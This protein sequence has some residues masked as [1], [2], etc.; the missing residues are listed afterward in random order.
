ME[1]LAAC[2]VADVRHPT[3]MQLKRLLDIGVPHSR[4]VRALRLAREAPFSV[5]LVEQ[6]HGGGA[7]IL[8]QHKRMNAETLVSCSA[9]H[10][11]RHFFEPSEIDKQ[12][13]KIRVKLEKLQSARASF[14]GLNLFVQRMSR[15][16]FLP[17]LHNDIDNAVGR[18]Q[19]SLAAGHQLYTQLP[20]SAKVAFSDAARSVRANR[21]ILIAE[22]VAEC[23][24]ELLVLEG[25]RRDVE[26]KSKPNHM[27]S[28]RLD[29]SDIDRMCEMSCSKDFQGL[30]VDRMNIDAVRPPAVPTR[31][32]QS[33]IVAEETACAIPEKPRPWWLQMV[34]L[35]R[36]RFK[37]AAFSW[38]S[39]RAE[40][41]YFI[42]YST[43]SPY[44]VTFLRLQR[45]ERVLP[46][47][48][49]LGPAERLSLDELLST[50]FTYCTYTFVLD[51]ELLEFDEEDMF[52][53][54]DLRFEDDI[55]TTRSSP[56]EFDVFTARFPRAAARARVP[57]QGGQRRT[58]FKMDARAELLNEFPWLTEE[59][60]NR[61]SGGRR[62]CGRRGDLPNDENEGSGS[63][64]DGPGP[65]FEGVDLLA[66]HDEVI[67]VAEEVRAI[68]EEFHFDAV[69]MAF[70]TRVLAGRWT[71][72]HRHV[73]A[74]AIA[75]Y[76]RGELAKQ[77]CRTYKLPAQKSYAFSV[78][79]HAAANKLATEYCRRADLFYQI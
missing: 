45:R 4:V 46:A 8:R 67:D 56:V 13:A 69:E 21:R 73:P 28:F 65:G 23:T 70:Y 39:P 11:A 48:E 51:E 3:V 66:V 53:W 59:Y 60:F 38:G 44:A 49:E 55:V 14:S 2:A 20:H 41:A 5:S 57:G 54:T 16:G 31:E 30:L 72:A 1:K 64:S 15:R 50:T 62:D 40:G 10:Q 36:D 22:A 47:V 18:G 26:S 52:A 35:N 25:R 19:A 61:I 43:L 58:D 33:I 79:G 12:I 75:G 63:G 17:T 37:D 7:A 9:L 76:A 71:M 6:A 42:M 29:F 77:W 68:R 24:A 78:Y 74:D 34:A 27:D 32:Q